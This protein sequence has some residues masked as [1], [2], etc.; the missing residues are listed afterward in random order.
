MVSV[1]IGSEGQL[2]ELGEHLGEGGSGQVYAATSEIS[3]VVHAIKLVSKRG[4]VASREALIAMV[5]G[6]LNLPHVVPILDAGKTADSWAF[7]MPKADQSL[8]KRLG[9]RNRVAISEPEAL[10]ILADITRGLVS[11]RDARAYGA[12]KPGIIHRDLK[13]GNV[14]LLNDKWC[15]S[16]FGLARAI[17]HDTATDT[18]RYHMSPPYAAPERWSGEAA[19]VESDIY[20]LGIVAFEMVMGRLP[21]EG[22]DFRLQHLNAQV[23]P[24]PNVSPRL[25]SLIIE[26]LYKVAA[27]RPTPEVLLRRLVSLTAPPRAMNGLDALHLANLAEAGRVSD[28]TQGQHA[29]DA[30]AQVHKNRLATAAHQWETISGALRDTIR[31]AAPLSQQISGDGL[32]WRIQLG[33]ASISC[34]DFSEQQAT[35]GLPFDVRAYATISLWLDGEKLRT[36]SFWYCDAATEGVYLWYETAFVKEPN[37]NLFIA[38]GGL[39]STVATQCTYA[40]SDEAAVTALLNGRGGWP[41]TPIPNGEPGELIGRW[42]TWFGEAAQGIRSPA[43]LPSRS[44]WLRN[45][46]LAGRYAAARNQKVGRESEVHEAAVYPEVSGEA[47]QVIQQLGSGAH[48]GIAE[49]IAV[50]PHLRGTEQE[51][52]CRELRTRLRIRRTP[53]L[54]FKHRSDKQFGLPGTPS[55]IAERSKARFSPLKLLDGTRYEEFIFTSEHDQRIVLVERRVPSKQGDGMLL[56]A[57]VVR[58]SESDG[59]IR[60]DRPS[61]SLQAWF[62]GPEMIAP[63]VNTSDES[64]LQPYTPETAYAAYSGLMGTTGAMPELSGQM[65]LGDVDMVTSAPSRAFRLDELPAPRPQGKGGLPP[66]EP[67]ARAAPDELRVSEPPSRG[68]PRQGPPIPPPP[69]PP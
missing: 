48:D 8:W 66:R 24:M 62:S 25:A 32:T 54:V 38:S 35:T 65:P 11:L 52:V 53:E 55:R 10:S 15:V 57:F 36:H 23:P 12:K 30:Q 13:P 26:C 68:L 21:F 1:R 27:S 16:D 19:R 28:A 20:A 64:T 50:A 45:V 2:W 47:S 69:P 39:E 33:R 67:R 63:R 58:V 41:F 42:A 6:L 7:L 18:L 40:P 60:Q 14:L 43:V 37:S 5:G 22:P 61:P 59:A 31:E 17:G 46:S 4:T 44:D 49:A 3:D 56:Y 34:S 51:A 9:G 29:E